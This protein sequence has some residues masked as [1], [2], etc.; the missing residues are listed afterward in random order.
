M[1]K[2][3]KEFI[4]A[5]KVVELIPQFQNDKAIAKDLNLDLKGVK[6]AL[7]L[8]DSGATIPFISRYRKDM[9]G[10]LD[11]VQLENIDSRKEYYNDFLKRR[12]SILKIIAEQ[13]KLTPVLF[14]LIIAAQSREELEDLYLPYKKKRLTRA[15]KA[16][17]KG[18]QPLADHILGKEIPAGEWSFADLAG[19]YVDSEKGVKTLEEAKAGACDIVAETV[20]EHKELRET[21]RGL[22]RKKGLVRSKVISSKKDQDT[23]FNDYHDY[24]ESVSKISPHRILA[25][26]RGEKEEVLRF[27]IK[28]DED[29]AL[30]IIQDYFKSPYPRLREIWKEI[31]TDSFKRLLNSSLETETK[32]YLKEI[33]DKK[34]IEI[35]R[36]NLREILMAPPLGEKR[37]LAIDPG[38]RT[39]CKVVALSENGV[40]LKY[41]AIFPHPPRGHWVLAKKQLKAMI[42]TYKIEAVAVGNGTAG[43]ETEKLV[44]EM[45]TEKMFSVA[46][47]VVRVDESGASIYSASKIA[48]KEFPD[49]DVTVRGAI[50]I[51]RRL[52][53]PLGE[54]VKIDPKS[55]GVGQYQYD[56]N[57]KLLRE[58]LDMVVLSSVNQVGVEVNTASRSLLQYVSGLGPGLAGKIIKYR[59]Q[60]GG[61]ESRKELKNVSGL[62]AKSFEQCAGFIRVA[63]SDIPLDHSGVH[64]ES[65]GVVFD[66]SK[67]L[68]LDLEQMI[69][70]KKVLSK[71]T[72]QKYSHLAGEYTLK[73]ILAELEKPGR[74]PRDSFE[75]VEFREDV[76]EMEDL[77][78][79]MIL[80]GVVT[81]VTGFGAFVDVGVHQ[82]GLVHI[83]ELAHR[84]VKEPTD[85]VKPGQKVTVKVIKLALRRKRISLSIKAC[86]PRQRKADSGR[87]KT[88]KNSNPFA[89]HF[90]K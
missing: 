12:E 63:R 56:V 17:K 21:L 80:P 3:T 31:R 11:E 59:D 34:S 47:P 67:D 54:L 13:E 73:D 41:R 40:P 90:N 37:V 78:E 64:P 2:A 15:E 58:S 28:V 23:T 42:D 81:N 39:G 33:A 35:F 24:K 49:L 26:F 5:D 52:Q 9:T 4:S 62:G 14:D 87:K 45:K 71:I 57:Q 19:A 22:Y 48:R 27:H 55:L 1:N 51:G 60:K 53:D 75:A 8:L 68:G 29:E 84:Y 69:G 89:R 50:S 70:N 18:L 30:G 88:K 7:D 76:Q 25:I 44:K 6:T 82:D 32:K 86:K 46:I 65:Y 43:R 20:S 38:F 61:F 36:S 83:S 77:E 10:G 66:I 16:R 85:V 74:D 79:G 72:L